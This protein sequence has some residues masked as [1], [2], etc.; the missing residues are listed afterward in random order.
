MIL[1]SWQSK[2]EN[3]MKL[4]TRGQH[5][6]THVLAIVSIALFSSALISFLAPRW[7]TFSIP[8]QLACTLGVGALAYSIAVAFC[9]SHWGQY[10]HAPCLMLAAVTIP[11]GI[12]VIWTHMLYDVGG[13]RV[14][15]TPLN[16]RDMPFSITIS[17]VMLVLCGIAWYRC[18]TTASLVGVIVY[19]HGL[20]FKIID[21]LQVAQ[22]VGQYITEAHFTEYLNFVISIVYFIIGHALEQHY[23]VLAWTLRFVAPLFITLYL[24]IFGGWYLAHDYICPLFW[25]ILWPLFST[26]LVALGLKRH[27]N[28][29]LIS[30]MISLIAFIFVAGWEYGHQTLGVPL[31]LCLLGFIFLALSYAVITLKRFTESPPH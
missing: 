5:I 17:S 12:R 11:W 3:C 8:L 27:D 9:C 2:K 21:Y 20:F 4:S 1:S 28:A 16:I 31:L 14:D 23:H 18:Q 7:E 25:R 6:L 29:L 22:Y 19:T 26:T 15:F 10:L 30:G 13:F 24:C